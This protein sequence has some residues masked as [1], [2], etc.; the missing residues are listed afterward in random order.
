M[1][2]SSKPYQSFLTWLATP[3]GQEF[4]QAE[5]ALFERI[6]SNCHGNHLLFVGNQKF[7]MVKNHGYFAHIHYAE[8]KNL[9]KKLAYPDDSFNCIVMP[10]TLE[11]VEQPQL[12]LQEMQR[13]LMPEGMIL[14]S[15]FQPYSYLQLLSHFPWSD[16]QALQP[17]KPISHTTLQQQLIELEFSEVSVNTF[18][19]NKLR[20]HLPYLTD[21]YLICAS[22]W[23]YNMKPLRVN[24]AAKPARLITCPGLTKVPHETN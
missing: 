14:I 19:S 6:L 10:H 1:S 2:T 8:L 12:V 9:R 23:R 13:L 4:L 21:A 18:S 3:L 24:Q 16:Y 11:F 20:N 7:N 5:L 22:K 17:I 15:G